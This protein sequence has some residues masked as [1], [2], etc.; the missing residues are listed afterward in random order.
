MIDRSTRLLAV[1]ALGLILISVVQGRKAHQVVTDKAQA[2]AN[3]TESV[4]RWKQ[5]YLALGDS[6]RRWGQDYRNQESV[7]DLMTLIALVRLGEYGLTVNTDA[8]TINKIEPVT[9]GSMQIGLTKVCLASS[10][11][12]AALE[13]QAPSYQALFKGFK[14]LAKRPDIS[15]D[16]ISIKGDRPVPVASFGDFCVLLSK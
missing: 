5:D 14:Q 11:M 15:I 7:P 2:Q 12:G 9:Q 8:V 13:V 1:M 6:V 16:T 4:N 10:S 3:V